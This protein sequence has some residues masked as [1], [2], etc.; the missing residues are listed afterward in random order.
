MPT[1]KTTITKA[2][3]AKKL[4]EEAN[5]LIEEAKQEQL[6]I[7][8]AAIGELKELGFSYSLTASGA[9]KTAPK[10]AKPSAGAAKSTVGYNAAKSC[11]I[12]NTAG[13]DG[14]AHRN[15]EPKQA[16]TAEELASRG[17]AAQ[18]ATA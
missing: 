12:C 18:A 13:H 7:I 5:G 14:R 15:Q 9:S 6:D 4:I 2:Q 8:T 1:D 11:P 3:R 10:T 16:F 17:L